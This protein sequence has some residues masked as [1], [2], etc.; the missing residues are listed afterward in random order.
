MAKWGGDFLGFGGGDGVGDLRRHAGGGLVVARL[1][2]TTKILMAFLLKF[3]SN[4]FLYYGK[5]GQRRT[6]LGSSDQT[7]K[8]RCVSSFQTPLSVRPSVS[9][10]H[11]TKY[12]NRLYPFS[13][14]LLQK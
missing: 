12:F 7:C 8:T 6:E 11:E 5:T 14:I 9:T 3:S 13:V 2:L 10:R 1:Y 4:R